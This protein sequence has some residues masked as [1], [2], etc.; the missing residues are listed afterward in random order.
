MKNR[1]GFI[2]I[3]AYAVVSVIVIL[4]SVY[5]ARSISEIR[6]A[7]RDKDSASALYAAEA[8]IDFAFDWLKSQSSPPA[9]TAAFSIT[10]GTALATG[11]YTVVVDPDDSNPTSFTKRYRIIATGIC[12]DSSRR[13]ILEVVQDTFAR[14]IWFTDSETYNGATVWFIT[15]DS[16]NGPVHTNGRFNISG[17]PWFGDE[18]SQSGPS[19]NYMHGGP[20][21]DNPTFVEGIDFNVDASSM[22]TRATNLRSAAALSGGMRLYGETTVV[23]NSNGTMNVTNANAGYNNTN[24]ALPANGA[25][26]VENRIVNRRLVE[27]GNVN[28]RGTLNGRLSIGANNN[29]R[30]GGNVN[31][32]DAAGSDMLGLIAERN[33][34]I[35]QSACPNNSDLT[36]QASMMAMSDSFYLENWTSTMKGTLNVLGGIIQKERGP[37]GT[38]N[39]NTNSK[40]SGFTK[41]YVYDERLRTTPPPFFPTTEDFVPV[42]WRE[43]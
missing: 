18:T 29:I 41:N 25:L 3:F 34:I 30:I 21:N 2:L 40:V 28:V 8:G 20:P 12:G 22:P 33:L 23:L 24:M 26:F 17:N 36:I 5:V 38:F 39:T 31:Y 19:I 27:Y 14:H 35:N 10:G 42:S 11:T 43:Q 6:T 9:G 1:K 7:V 15:N 16:L 4:V 32:N 13:V 37:V